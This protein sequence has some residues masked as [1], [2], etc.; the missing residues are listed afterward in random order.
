MDSVS[1]AI[2]ENNAIGYVPTVR[3][4]PD[5]SMD[6]CILQVEQPFLYQEP[7]TSCASHCTVSLIHSASDISF[8]RGSLFATGIITQGKLFLNDKNDQA[9]SDYEATL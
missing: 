7:M 6:T 1:L 3:T 8:L 9:I 5:I 4:T 2:L